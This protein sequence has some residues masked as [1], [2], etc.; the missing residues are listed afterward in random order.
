MVCGR[1]PRNFDPTAAA[2]KGKDFGPTFV[3][4]WEGDTLVP[5]GADRGVEPSTATALAVS[6]N[7]III[8]TNTDFSR[9][10]VEAAGVLTYPKKRANSPADTDD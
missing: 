2:S 1:R 6:R 4:R 10:G 9:N 7:R 8:G 5:D 3:Y